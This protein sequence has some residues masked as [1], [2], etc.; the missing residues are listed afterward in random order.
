MHINIKIQGYCLFDYSESITLTSKPM[1]PAIDFDSNI[2]HFDRIT[3]LD[4]KIIK[5]L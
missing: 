4:L 5:Q 3:N 2:S 1:H